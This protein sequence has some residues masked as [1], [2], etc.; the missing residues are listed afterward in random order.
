MG[1]KGGYEGGRAIATAALILFGGKIT[2][3]VY[4]ATSELGFDAARRPADAEHFSMRA[5]YRSEASTHDIHL[6]LNGEG[7]HFWTASPKSAWMFA[8]DG[9]INHKPFTAGVTPAPPKMLSRAEIQALIAKAVRG[10]LASGSSAA[11]KPFARQ[12]PASPS[13]TASV[14]EIPGSPPA[15]TSESA[16]GHNDGNATLRSD[17]AA[18]QHSHSPSGADAANAADEQT[19]AS[20]PDTSAEPGEPASKGASGDADAS[21]SGSGAA[22]SPAPLRRS[23]RLAPRTQPRAAQRGGSAKPHGSDVMEIDG[24]DDGAPSIAMDS[25][26]SAL[27]PRAACC[28]PESASRP[29]RQHAGLFKGASAPAAKRPRAEARTAE[30]S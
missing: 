5:S 14:V 20:Q 13:S 2:I 30:S 12:Q 6:I 26:R 15:Q 24:D 3:K 29:S 8:Q 4:D 1:G 25:N 23:S 11:A 17:G 9:S 27:R 21:N 22:A 7:T 28:D 19:G 10:P 16:A 18:E